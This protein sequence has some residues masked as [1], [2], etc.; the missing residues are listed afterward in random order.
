MT[1]PS[2]DRDLVG[3]PVKRIT[4]LFVE[5]MAI[6]IF[7]IPAIELEVGA[8]VVWGEAHHHRLNAGTIELLDASVHFS[9]WKAFSSRI[10]IP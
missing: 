7:G 6:D 10:Y 1:F 8:G 3:R 2:Y 5:N 9:P 4:F